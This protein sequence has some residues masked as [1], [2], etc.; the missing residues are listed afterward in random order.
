MLNSSFFKKNKLISVSILILLLFSIGVFLNTEGFYNLIETLSIWVR[1]N[2]GGFY[3]A[4]G[5][6]CV[7]F[8]L[9]LAISPLGK[10]RLGG[11]DSKIEFSNLS[12]I[13]MLYSTGMGAGILLRAVQEPVYM[14]INPP[15][16]GKATKEVIALEYTFYQWGFTAWAFYGLF[17]LVI[18]Y[19]IFNKNRPSLASSAFLSVS[20]SS[21]SLSS[22]DLLVI[23]TTVF[24][25]IGALGLGTTQLSAGVEHI[26][27]NNYGIS[28]SLLFTFLI[29]AIAF[30]SVYNGIDKGIKV[31]S[32]INIFIM[33]LLF[34]F[35]IFQNDLFELLNIF[36][37]AFYRYVID[38]VQLSLALGDYNPG[39]SFLTDWTYYYWAFWL[40]WAPFTGIFIARI[41]KGR[42]IR[43]ILMGVLIVPSL[44]TFLWFSS[45]GNIAFDLIESWGAYNGEFDNVFS[46]I[47]VF[48][49]NF[50]W[51][52]FIEIIVIILLIGFLA[53]SIDSA[54]Y[55][56]SMF[57]DK[58]NQNPKKFHRILW[59]IFLLIFT[60][61][62][63]FLGEAKPHIDV[64]VALQ[65][66]LIVTSLPFSLLL[67]IAA[68][69][70]L[71][72]L[73]KSR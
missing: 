52:S 46:S 15:I 14:M 71:V 59:A 57:T 67:V 1:N 61:A 37:K 31:I 12:W 41:S 50:Q 44:G 3:L 60:I 43:Q 56:L 42:S 55:V 28:M 39:K 48:F 63:L 4:L 40:A 35:V 68:I 19:Y 49:E 24:G 16:N 2:F 32:R 20:R 64:L 62:I 72:D 27:R 9:I 25:L 69:I 21:F 17:A 5:I 66:L 33:S 7:F 53:T 65:K 34:V 73:I 36:G 45:F 47:F 10:I 18:G 6:G 54:I 22:I 26:S 51:S 70:F 38:F 11:K 23:L 58:G 29:C 8:I 30:L 13:A